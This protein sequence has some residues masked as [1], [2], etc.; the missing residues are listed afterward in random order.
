M[1]MSYSEY[2]GCTGCQYLD[3]DNGTC[4]AD[5]CVDEQDDEE[6]KRG[7]LTEKI[8]RIAVPL[9]GEDFDT[10]QLR[11]LVYVAFVAVNGGRIEGQKISPS[12]WNI[13]K[14]WKRMH[15]LKGE[16]ELQAKFA[17]NDWLRIHHI[18]YLAY[19]CK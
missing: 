17:L 12:E 8:K 4:T 2:I 6:A 7:M 5:I 11:L 14:R 15:I 3:T 9:F 19:H 18:L 16:T 1:G 10:V 13:L